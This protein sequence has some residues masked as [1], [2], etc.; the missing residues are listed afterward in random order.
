[1]CR[2]ALKMLTGDRHKYLVLVLGV[3]FATVLMSDQASVFWSVMRRTTSQIRDTHPAGIWVMGPMALYVD[4][5]KPLREQDLYRVR[6][7]AGVAWAVPLY[8]GVVHAQAGD[9]YRQVVL[10]GVD[11]R[12]LVGAP[13][14]MLLGRAEDLRKPDAVI[15][16]ELGH[17]LL[18]PGEPMRLGRELEINERRAVLVG[19]CRASPLFQTLPILYTEFGQAQ[20][21]TP[22]ERRH[23]SFVLAAPQPG[24][25]IQEVCQ[26]IRAQTGL[27]AV[28]AEEFSSSTIAYYF[29]Y[30]GIPLNFIVI[31]SI[32][33]V[34]GV[35]VAG[36][37]FYLFMVDN[38]RQFGVLKALGADNRTLLR[39][40]LFQ[41][42]VI[43]LLGY[44]VGIGLTAVLIEVT[45]KNT[46]HL[47][48]FFM[49]WQVMVGTAACVLVIMIL[50]SLMSIR[51]VFV[52]EAAAVFQ[53]NMAADAGPKPRR[54]VWAPQGPP[55]AGLW[56]RR[57]R[58]EFGAAETSTVALRG[59]ELHIAA[60][61]LSLLVGPSG[62]GK[63]T[64]LSVLSGLLDATEGE[65]WALGVD[66]GRLS[67]RQR[68]RFRRDNVGF[69]FQ[70]F[71]LLPALTAAENVAV[72]LLL[73]GCPRPKALNRVRACLAQ[74][75]L[76]DRA[77]ALPSQLSGGQQQRVAIARA[78]VHE[79]RILV[80]DEPT[81][82]L[83]A[84]AGQSVM[85]LLYR[86][87]VQPTRVVLVVTHDSRV[88][89]F[90]DRVLHM[91]DG[92]IVDTKTRAPAPSVPE[93][94]P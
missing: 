11:H 18:W 57:V 78:L 65:V 27:L 61:E 12:T 49:P 30:T 33:F 87:A 29:R 1:M 80:C 82:A 10:L 73:A 21:F 40:I 81:S 34:V 17:S 3:A 84:Q 52:L 88:Y 86:V 39:M 6:G 32:G 4:E 20:H 67:P 70:Q 41:A 63:T 69:V 94:H 48:G 89:A 85:E 9:L 93:S 19:V 24:I 74:L 71:Q 46:L 31:V 64:L 60:G 5:F 35:A 14:E 16:D 53:G 50:S 23:T 59:V 72:P 28:P 8:K 2:I 44:G 25:P 22:Q 76:G 54:S 38:L 37:T 51:R 75:G 58:K 91:E 66:L 15:V 92:R 26:R 90:G 62:C 56:C 36:Q 77:A 55:H 42:L 79:P 43:G 13:R 47:A 83:D 45:T 68:A 7:V